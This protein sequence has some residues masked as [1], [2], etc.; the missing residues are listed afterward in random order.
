MCACS[1]VARLEHPAFTRPRDLPICGSQLRLLLADAPATCI[2]G[3]RAERGVL[4][5][6]KPT[7]KK[8][9]EMRLHSQAHS[10]QRRLTLQQIAGREI[11]NGN[12]RQA[13]LFMWRLA[14]DGFV[15]ISLTPGDLASEHLSEKPP[16]HSFASHHFS[17]V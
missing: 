15:E 2:C 7:C 3:G 13:N 4:Q 8:M 5:L 9:H 16:G 17:R 6:A 12:L 1:A 11:S 10:P 14:A